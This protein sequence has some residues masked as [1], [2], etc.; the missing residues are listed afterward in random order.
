MVKQY[1]GYSYSAADQQQVGHAQKIFSVKFHP[2]SPNLFITGGWDN[3]IKVCD[4]TILN[5]PGYALTTYLMHNPAF[6][7]KSQPL[8]TVYRGL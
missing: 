5:N 6:R 4:A 2:E 1:S 3:H 7:E 8:T